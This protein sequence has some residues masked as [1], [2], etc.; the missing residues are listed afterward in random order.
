[1]QGGIISGNT[2][3]SSSSYDMMNGIRSS[4]PIRSISDSSSS[5]GGVH[6][7]GTFTMYNSASLSGNTSSS[8]SNGGYSFSFSISSLSSSG[9]GVYNSGTFTIQDSAS[10]SGNTSYSTS[11]GFT[12]EGFPFP[13]LSG[14]GVH[15]SGTFTM[16]ERASVS[17]NISYSSSGGGVYV[18]S[19]TF[20]K[21]GGNIYGNDAEQNLKNTAVGG[22]GHTIYEDKSKGWRN[23]SAGPTINSDSYGFWLNEDAIQTLPAGYIGT[24]KRSNFNNTLTFTEKTVRI[25]SN[26]ET[27][28]IIVISGVLI[29]LK[30]GSANPF[31]LTFRLINGNLVISGDSGNGENNWNGTWYKQR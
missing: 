7:S 21:T 30:R 25:S 1:M 17:G 5:G 16:K 29:K 9:G 10:V 13:D 4:S 6:N 27:Y 18:A 20:T 2:S 26:P 8:E 14:G 3:T 22:K 28:N 15:N 31:T 24:W 11:G 19:G 12:D 23:A